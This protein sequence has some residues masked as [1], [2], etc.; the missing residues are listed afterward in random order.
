MTESEQFAEAIRQTQPA[1]PVY[2]LEFESRERL[3]EALPWMLWIKRPAPGEMVVRKG[4]AAR[5]FEEEG[6]AILVVGGELT[7]EERQQLSRIARRFGATLTDLTSPTVPVPTS[8]EQ[9]VAA[10]QRRRMLGTLLTWGAS[11]LVLGAALALWALRSPYTPIGTIRLHVSEYD[12][13]V[14]TV[15]GRVAGSSNL[16][17]VSAY[18][19][20]DD[21]GQI[22]VVT[23]GQIPEVNTARVVKGRVVAGFVAGPVTSL[24]LL[25]E[26]ATDVTPAPLSNSE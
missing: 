10:A 23:H 20:Q 8:G 18:R 14:V 15:R 9:K 25:E 6:R 24:V 3:N 26:S 16:M 12:G 1:C 7:A 17:G 2:R 13:K 22:A 5:G 4:V 19:L 21:T 11:V